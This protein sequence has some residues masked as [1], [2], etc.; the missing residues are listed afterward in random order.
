MANNLYDSHDV[1]V[2]LFQDIA[3][4]EF[5][6]FQERTN[7]PF[8]LT[9]DDFGEGFRL[10][11]RVQLPLDPHRICAYMYTA[12]EQLVAALECAP[13]DPMRSVGILPEAERDQL[14][15]EW[16]NTKLDYP[17][18][19]LIHQLFQ[20]QAER[21]PGR[22]A[23][24]VGSE[25]LSY[26]EL[27]DRA[28]RIARS[29]RLHGVARGQ[30]VG[31]CVERGADMVAAVLGI[32]MSG[33]AYVPLDPAYPQERL[34]FVAQDAE[35]SLLVSTSALASACGLPRDRQLLLDSELTASA[36]MSGGDPF[37]L[38]AALDARPEDP[39]Y[40]IYTSGS[41]GKP[42]GVVVLHQAV[43]NFLTSMAREPGMIADDVLVAVTTLSF[44]IAVLE[45]QLPLALGATVVLATRDEAIDGRALS[46][47]LEQHRATV[48]QA[49]PATWRLLLDAGWRG[50]QGFKALVGG[51][52]LPTDLADQ[53]I[54]S[55]I[56]LWNLY[57]PTESTIWSTLYR[58][59]RADDR[60][61]VGR[62]IANTEIYILDRHLQPVPVGVPGEL[63]IGG[64]GLAL[65]YLNR[66][67]LTVEK[68]VRH[69]F[70]NDPKARLYKTGDLARYRSD[71]NIEYLGRLDHQ[72]KIR[73]FR[74]ELGE[75]ESV[76]RDHPNL[77]DAV[78]VARED[79]EGKKRLV[80][81]VVTSNESVPA[82]R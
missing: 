13:N 39:A 59:E 54:S 61:P 56:E 53:L 63:H 9:V 24:K 74:I 18:N 57:G 4:R 52:A 60:I 22:T 55:G 78:V 69:P 16:N 11:A 5:L 82:S 7:Y 25:S 34:R 45:L 15:N 26:A 40:V 23:L 31:L 19:K 32:L 3:G 14:L 47:L 80:A 1:P 2:W 33:A 46:A 6:N 8:E 70:S 72:V 64:V 17:E 36:R 51:E 12:L 67:E 37:E 35:L 71:G 79:N 81:Y 68:F 38:E 44:D 29:L 62:P 27:N 76:L 75:I 20:V 50:R 73:G 43:V 42:K 49:T 30:R 10:D 58:V 66:P 21:A 28:C 48:M 65:G 77:S 41:T